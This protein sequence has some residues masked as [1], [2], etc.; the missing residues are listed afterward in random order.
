MDFEP[1]KLSCNIIKSTRRCRRCMYVCVRR[2]GTRDERES[3][4]NSPSQTTFMIIKRVSVSRSL[5][6]TRAR[7]HAQRQEPLS[8]KRSAGPAVITTLVVIEYL[9][10]FLMHAVNRSKEA[11]ALHCSAARPHYKGGN[12]C[13]RERERAREKYGRNFTMMTIQQPSW[14][15][16]LLA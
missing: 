1:R 10:W 14:Q 9:M 13:Q 8:H 2:I 5:K 6:H 4:M 7:A 3:E 16:N 12:R 15:R 11:G